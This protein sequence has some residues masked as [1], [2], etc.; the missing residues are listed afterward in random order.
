[1]PAIEAIE[2]V[3]R[4]CRRDRSNLFI[5]RSLKL[6]TEGWRSHREIDCRF[7]SG[8]KRGVDG[9]L[10]SGR[11]RNRTDGAENLAVKSAVHLASHQKQVDA[12]QQRAR[13]SRQVQFGPIVREDVGAAVCI[14][15]DSVLHEVQ[16]ADDSRDIGHLHLRRHQSG[17][18]DARARRNIPGG[19]PVE[20]GGRTK[21][22]LTESP[23]RILRA[24]K[25]V[26]TG[27]RLGRE[28]ARPLR[29]A[30]Q[31]FPHFSV[32]RIAEAVGGV[33]CLRVKQDRGD[34]C[35]QIS[36]H[37]LAIVLEHRG[38]TADVAGAWIA[39]HEML[40]HLLREKCG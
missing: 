24:A 18:V 13:C 22:H 29:V 8:S 28:C 19:K 3:L 6:R 34:D 26:R 5:V 33:A 25:V 1:M 31:R 36:A 39:G 14:S 16:V 21:R 10:V 37:S 30:E 17:L 7:H 32:L 40:D 12:V 4:N 35:F 2:A 11:N 23:D 15:A 38:H 27:A 9:I 20:N